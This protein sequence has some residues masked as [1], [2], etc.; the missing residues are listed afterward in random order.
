MA[1]VIYRPEQGASDVTE[2]YGY[3]FAGGQPVDVTDER[4]LMKFRGNRF[5]E[6]DGALVEKK[7]EAVDPTPPLPPPAADKYE[8]KH[9]GGGKYAVM[10]G[11]KVIGDATMTKE[12]AEAF[13]T[14]SDDDKAAY[15]ATIKPAE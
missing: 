1:K 7:A 5:F 4:H 3:K 9:R 13:N 12:E 15:V 2:Q 10:L 6:V 8:A 11:D 14:W